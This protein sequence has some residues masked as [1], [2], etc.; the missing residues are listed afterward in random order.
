M[1][2]GAEDQ[3]SLIEK[4]VEADEVLTVDGQQIRKSVVGDV[5]FAVFKSQEA[6][7]AKSEE[8][9]RLE[10]ENRLFQ[11]DI[12]KAADAWP[13]IKGTDIEK[14]S[15]FAIIHGIK[16]E[17]VKKYALEVFASAN[18]VVSKTLYTELGSSAE[19]DINLDT[20][21]GQYEAMAKALAKE[22]GIKVGDA[23]IELA[24]TVEG[25]ALYAQVKKA[26]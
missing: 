5:S 11:E 6:R 2:K 1:A 14:G 4:S 21:Q 16:N 8:V 20:P 23:Y 17:D 22:N 18:E 3:V 15:L 24:K 25:K 19:F 12:K 10:K 7:I 13:N 9:A 26:R